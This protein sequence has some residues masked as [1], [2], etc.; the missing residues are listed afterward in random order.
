M[1]SCRCAAQLLAIAQVGLI[2]LG[3]GLALFP[4]IVPSDLTLMDTAAPDSVLL[5]ISIVLLIGPT[6]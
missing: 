5:P 3:F 6:F 4:Y 2:V 1:P